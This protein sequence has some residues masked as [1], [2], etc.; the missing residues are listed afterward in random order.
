LHDGNG[1][2]SEHKRYGERSFGREHAESANIYSRQ[3]HNETA[4]TTD[5][6]RQ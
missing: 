2:S 3:L 6:C 5:D 4:G 1:Y